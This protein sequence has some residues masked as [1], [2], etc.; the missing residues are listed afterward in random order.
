MAW[1]SKA[2]QGEYPCFTLTVL[3][4]LNNSLKASFDARLLVG[5]SP[6]Q[7]LKSGSQTP[8][9]GSHAWCH[10]RKKQTKPHLHKTWLS[11][12]PVSKETSHPKA[13]LRHLSLIKPCIW[14]TSSQKRRFWFYT[15]F[16]SPA[17]S[18][19]VTSPAFH[20]SLHVCV[21]ERQTETEKHFFCSNANKLF[22]VS[23][24]VATYT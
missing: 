9:G 20:V 21:T 10:P 12:D 13:V 7:L 15:V 6:P 8:S 19:K 24:P 14:Q 5:N 22:N 18:E 1:Y 17:L 4:I 2:K 23:S 11:A 16:Q 3:L